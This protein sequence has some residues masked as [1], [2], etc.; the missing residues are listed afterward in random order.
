MTAW[1]TLPEPRRLLAAIKLERPRA[2]MATD[3]PSIR[4][5]GKNAAALRR[6]HNALLDEAYELDRAEWERTGVMGP[7]YAELMADAPDKIIGLLLGD[8]IDIWADETALTECL[9]DP[10]L[11]RSA[12]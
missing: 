2:D 9:P 10:F 12:A 1:H 5:E 8:I 3:G 7:R 4:Y 11:N 6:I